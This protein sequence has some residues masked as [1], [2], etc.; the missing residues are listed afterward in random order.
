[1]GAI[2]RFEDIP[3]ADHSRVVNVNLNGVIHGSHTALGLF[4]RQGSGTLVNIGS[5]E[6]EVPLAYQDSYAASKAGV[7]ALGRA[8]KEE[9]RLAGLSGVQVATVMPWAADTPFFA[10]TGNYSGR[11]PGMVALDPPDKVVEAIVWVSVNPREVR[12][13]A[14]IDTGAGTLQPYGRFNVDKTSSGADAASFLNGATLTD[15]SAPTGGRSTELAG[16]LTLALG[17]TTSL[18]GEIGKL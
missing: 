18:Y 2:G 12:V 6:S 16:G 10:H 4:R 11:E 3:V 17:Q 14:E 9:L 1:M 8:L 15:I 7:L 13:K 5:V